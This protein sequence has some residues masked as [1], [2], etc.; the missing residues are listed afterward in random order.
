[1]TKKL[2]ISLIISSIIIVII[3]GFLS[4][5]LYIIPQLIKVQSLWD[6][7]N[8]IIH[9]TC[10][11]EL[12]VDKPVLKTS[13]SPKIEFSINRLSLSKNGEM[14]LNLENFDTAINFAKLI[15]KEI[16]LKKLTVDDVYVDFNKLQKLSFKEQEQ[17]ETTPSPIT[18]DWFNALLSIKRCIVIYNPNEKVL[19]KFL[20]GDITLKTE[21]NKKMLH[22]RSLVDMEIANERLRIA[23]KDKNNVY[24][25]NDKLHVDNFKFFVNKSEIIANMHVDKD[26]KYEVSLTS[27]KF[28]IHNI[29][30]IM[31]SNLLVPNGNDIMN[32]FN[33]LKGFFNFKID[34]ATNKI[35]AQIN[36]D[37]ITANLPSLANI[38]IVL[39]KGT[40]TVDDKQV[41]F[42]DFEGFYCGNKKYL[43]KMKG[44]VANYATKPLTKLIISG[45]A[46]DAFAKYISKLAGIKISLINQT[47]FLI[48]VICDDKGRINVKGGAKVPVGSDITFEGASISSTKFDRAVG[49]DMD[50]S[51]ENL[52]INHINYY[53]SEKIGKK[54][55]SKPLFT[56]S[57]KLNAFTGYLK[58]LSFDIPEPLPSEFFN[59]LIGQK[60][61][62]FGTASG[63]VKFINGKVPKIFGDAK[64]DSVMIVG[65]KL[66]IQKG[67][68]GA[69]DDCIH[70]NAKGFFRRMNYNFDGD[71]EN[72]LLFPIVIHNVNFDID[73]IDVE[74]V[75]KSFAPR[76]QNPTQNQEK[77]PV[78]KDRPEIAKSNI[79]TKYFEV[80][81]K[82]TAATTT[83]TDS[84]SDTEQIVFQPN[85]V[86]VK[87]CNFNVTKGSYKDIKFGNLHALLTLT[88]E[89]ILNIQSN[90]FDFADGIST[91]KVYC[92]MVKQQYSVRLGAKEVN[93]DTIAS[94]ILN[95][96]KEIS[97]KANALLEFNTDASAKLNGKIQFNVTNGSIT[98]LGLV[99]YILNVASIFRNPFAMISPATLVDLVNVPDGTFK[100]INGTLKI[101]DNNVQSMMIKSS[102]PQLS[103]FIVGRL[104]LET[105]D[106]SLRIYTKF[107]NKNKGIL[108]FLRALS[109]NTLSK[110][111]LFSTKEDASYYASELSMLP[112]LE[113]GEDTAQVFLTKFDG[114]ILTSN[115]VSQLKRIK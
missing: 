8:D 34:V 79:S 55:N 12:L 62:K 30:R 25:E 9:D 113:T 78:P 109:L 59:I 75:M 110:K 3:A 19:V 26:Y 99:Q 84:S 90:K 58:E 5:Y 18:I 43:I 83:T 101:K 20:S 95:L 88:K 87:S 82:Q 86:I 71:I 33:N 7:V 49:I 96:P 102:S 69:D 68:F 11:A 81:E 15:K 111:V 91:L 41:L 29:D 73:E 106:A 77:R 4:L 74:K 51:G 115:F 70:L 61:F 24:I 6:Y 105:M 1:M 92:D 48:Q 16:T 54:V 114:D 52:V 100:T 27:K 21:N 37:K 36:I 65:Q 98:K 112:K 66:V 10:G 63:N 64:L 108:G 13:L 17:K 50:L 2:K 44:D 42:K 104:N 31:R 76:P 45:F 35:A 53:I 80:E 40:I 57:G 32:C 85:L 38:P 14:L 103:S 107:N 72:N 93:T 47:N 60:L 67:Q 97:G 23:L 46:Y 22:F 39:D 28:D 89:G 94:T 56:I